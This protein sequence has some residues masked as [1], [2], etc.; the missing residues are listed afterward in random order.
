MIVVA[1][2]QSASPRRNVEH[3]R[4][5]LG[6]VHLS[7][8]LGEADSRAQRPQAL[9]DLVQRVDPVVQ[10]EDLAL[11]RHLALD[12]ALDQLLVVGAD[13]GADRAPALGRR[14]DHRDVAQAGEAHLQ[15]ARDRR[16]RE[17]EH[18]DLQL[19]LAQQ[20]L[21][22]DAEALLLVD[23]HE[24]EVLRPHVAREQAV[25]ADQDVDA[26]RG[27]ARERVADLGRLAQARDHLDLQREVGQTLAEGAQVL[28]G[29]DRRRHQHHHLLAARPRPCGRRAARPRSCR[30]RRRRRSAGP[31]GART[32]CR[33]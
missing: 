13:V 19:Q 29:E 22:L 5:E 26:S 15:R 12:R 18:V 6:L 31:S 33:P 4:L 16:R 9:G 10:E 1:T 24:A 20:L 11:A 17:R 14:L 23:D 32:P 25:R 3:R 21:L 27:E 28:L 8:R 30:S 7:V 2:R